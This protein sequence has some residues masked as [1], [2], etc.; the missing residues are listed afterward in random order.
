MHAARSF[1]RVRCAMACRLPPQ[2]LHASA[3]KAPP[4][5]PPWQ[6]LPGAARHQQFPD[7]AWR[8]ALQASG[9]SAR[10][11]IACAF[12]ELDKDPAIFMKASGVRNRALWSRRDRVFFA[13]ARVKLKDARLVYDACARSKAGIA[14]RCRFTLP[15]NAAR[16]NTRHVRNGNRFVLAVVQWIEQGPPK[17]QMQVRFLPAGLEQAVTCA[18][19]SMRLQR[20]RRRNLRRS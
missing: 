1:S 18:R 13:S 2:A 6:R 5:R 15:C 16:R 3:R 19:G 9:W 10:V 8:A 20:F 17:T 4:S 7:A 12:E 14:R 11:P